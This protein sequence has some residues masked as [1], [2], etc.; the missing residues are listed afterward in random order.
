[1]HIPII[2]SR[3][4]HVYRGFY[5]RNVNAHTSRLKTWM[6]S[7][8]GVASLYLSSYLGWRR[9]LERHAESVA[10]ERCLQAAYRSAST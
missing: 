8:R 3:G 10:P 5:I 4:E 6:R 2:T 9:S 1:L 7:F